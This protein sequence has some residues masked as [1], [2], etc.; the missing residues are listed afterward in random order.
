MIGGNLCRCTGYANI[1]K[2]VPARRRARE[3]GRGVT[4][5]LFGSRSA[6]VEDLR[7]IAVR[8]G[9]PTTSGTTPPLHAAVLRSPTPT[10]DP[11]HRRGRRA[12]RRGRHGRLHL[13]GPRGPDGRA[14]AA[15]D[16]APHAHPR[17]HQYAAGPRRGQHVGEASSWWSPSTA[18]SPRT[19]SATGSASPT[20]SC[21]SWSGSTPPARPPTRCTTTCPATSPPGMEQETGDVEA[22]L[23]AGPHTLSLDLSTS[24]AAPA[25]PWRAGRARGVEPRRLLLRCAHLDPDL[26]LGARRVAAKLGLDLEKVDVITPDVGGGF[27]VKIVH[28]WPEELLVPMAAIALGRR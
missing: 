5:K 22:A 10:P 27:G 12:R 7:L 28:P 26:H 16:P 17:A 21:R 1:V 25:C 18:T 4:T 8:A 13:R 11:G 23:A 14:A 20:T 3:G 19:P 6:G 24:S 2:A 9:T 15:A